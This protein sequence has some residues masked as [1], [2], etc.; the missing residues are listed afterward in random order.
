M[1]VP[2]GIFLGIWLF[3]FG[4]IAFFYFAIFRRVPGPVMI[5]VDVFT[6]LAASPVVWIAAVMCVAVGLFITHSWSGR[7]GL[8]IALAVTE[9]IPVG[10]VVMFFVLLNR[11]KTFKT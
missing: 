4:T 9:L 11:L 1:W 10:L 5:G 6:H 3:S 7:T 2:K 8:W